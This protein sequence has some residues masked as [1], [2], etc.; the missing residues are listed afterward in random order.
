MGSAVYDINYVDQR[1]KANEHLL[2]IAG[3]YQKD[4]GIVF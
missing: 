1:K 3:E 4:S 2:Y